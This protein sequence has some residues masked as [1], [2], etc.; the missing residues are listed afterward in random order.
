[1]CTL[2]GG[3]LSD[4]T[5]QAVEPLGR[6]YQR[7]GSLYYHGLLALLLLL[8]RR[9]VKEWHFSGLTLQVGTGVNTSILQGDHVLHSPSGLIFSPKTK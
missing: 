4:A 1:M 9:P 6:I 8:V 7:G 5:G 3:A 2:N